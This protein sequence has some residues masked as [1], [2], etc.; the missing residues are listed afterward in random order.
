M[1][2]IIWDKLIKAFEKNRCI[3][4]LGPRLSVNG[5]LP[6]EEV[7]A[8]VLESELKKSGIEYDNQFVSNLSYMSQRYLSSPLHTDVD[9]Q[10]IAQEFYKKYN[11]PIKEMLDELA[12]LPFSIIITTTPDNHFEQALRDCSK[13]PFITYYDFYLS[14]DNQNQS[15]DKPA[16]LQATNPPTCKNPLVYKIFGTFEKPQSLVLTDV[17]QMQFVRNVVKSNP[18]IPPL[19]IGQLQRDK[20]YLFL[21]F[22]MENWQLRLLLDSLRLDQKCIP[23]M[24]EKDSPSSTRTRAFYIDHFKFDFIDKKIADFCKDLQSHFPTVTV[25]KHNLWIL[26]DDKDFALKNDLITH[27][28]PIKNIEIWHEQGF[29]LSTDIENER[30]QRAN[31]TTAILI[32]ISADFIAHYDDDITR[33]KLIETHKA[34]GKKIYI[35]V[36]RACLWQEDINFN[37][38]DF[39]HNALS[40]EHNDA[41]LN[42]LVNELK[43]SL[44]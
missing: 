20:T 40:L 32:L 26:A 15:V 41:V 38:A 28:K 42:L 30:I 16:E 25:Q 18:P 21:G 33:K 39:L 36:A 19:L 7:L 17:Q 27:L 37:Q 14:T 3:L 31:E 8:H 44:R 43:Q 10:D 11:S 34:G 13:T 23:F 4:F 29:D 6:I 22:D 9:L 12:R 1:S 35:A 5:S 24:P 2:A